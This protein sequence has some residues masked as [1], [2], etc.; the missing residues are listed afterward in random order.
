MQKEP[1]SQSKQQSGPEKPMMSRTEINARVVSRSES[2][3][4]NAR[5]AAR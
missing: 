1:S 4:I 2:I 3:G 5:Q